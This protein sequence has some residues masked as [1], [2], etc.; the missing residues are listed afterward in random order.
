MFCF[1]CR[2]IKQQQKGLLLTVH[3]TD[4]N[5]SFAY[6]ET[7]FGVSSL[8]GAK[9]QHYLF[10]DLS[11]NVIVISFHHVVFSYFSMN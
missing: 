3:T 1:L 5:F 6:G 2:G 4:T 8:F 10:L 9:V 11:K 7:E